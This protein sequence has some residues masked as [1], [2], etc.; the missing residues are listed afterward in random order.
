MVK[1]IFTRRCY[2]LL[3]I[4]PYFQVMLFPSLSNLTFDYL[5]SPIHLFSFHPP[6]LYVFQRHILAFATYSYKSIDGQTLNS[7]LLPTF[8]ILQHLLYW[9]SQWMQQMN[10]WYLNLY[11]LDFQMEDASFSVLVL[12]CVLHGND[13]GKLPHCVHGNYWLIYTH[14]CTSYWPTSLYLI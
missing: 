9:L 12:L 3:L 7:S 1:R 14:P 5:I 10:L 8:R 2:S 6:S 13:P 11:W 4:P